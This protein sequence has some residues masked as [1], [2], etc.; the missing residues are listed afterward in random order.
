[1]GCAPSKGSTIA[2]QPAV[3]PRAGPAT[4]QA[5]PPPVTPPLTLTNNR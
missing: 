2:V 5:N 3:T 4:R 1:M